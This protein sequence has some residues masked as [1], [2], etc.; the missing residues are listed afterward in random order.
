M[1]GG[2]S[3]SIEP[4]QDQGG[5]ISYPIRWTIQESGQTS[6]EGVPVQINASDGGVQLWDGTTIA[7]GI[8][9]FSIQNFDNLGTTGAGFPNPYSPILGPGSVI[10]NYRANANQPLAVITPPMV[11]TV[12]GGMYYCVAGPEVVF[13]GVIGSSSG[14]NAAIATNNNQVGVAYGLTA[15]GGTGN[16]FYFVDTNKTGSS[17]VLRIVGIDPRQPVGTVGGQVLF[18]I[19]SASAQIPV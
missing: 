10:G 6:V 7:A 13:S 14:S 15:D 17:A 12:D 19:L 5:A 3:T 16:P 18:V 11:P 4:Q 1:A 2:F 8:A 9:G